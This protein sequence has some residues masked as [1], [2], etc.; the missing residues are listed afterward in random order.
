[1]VKTT[2]SEGGIMTDIYLCEEI[3]ATLNSVQTARFNELEKLK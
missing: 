1:M 2:Y 3:Q